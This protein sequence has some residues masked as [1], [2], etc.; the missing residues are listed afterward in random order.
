M[1]RDRSDAGRRLAVAL[2]RFAAERP[3]VLAL[4][5]GGV[6]VAFEVARALRAPLDVVLVRKVGHPKTKELA[7][8]AVVDGAEPQVVL[9]RAAALAL[10]ATSAGIDAAVARAWQELQRREQLFAGHRPKVTLAD[11]TV[12]VIDDGIATGYTMRAALRRV[13]RERPRQSILAVPVAPPDS[14]VEL[15]SECDLVIC[16]HEP[17]SFRAVGES[18]ED[19]VQVTDDEVIALLDRAS[20]K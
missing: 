12:I 2:A 14:L 13:R 18:Y 10:G 16:L 3:V 9:D 8:G 7:I 6:P 11:R 5:R 1:F 17:S 19:F 15:R 20:G 4:P